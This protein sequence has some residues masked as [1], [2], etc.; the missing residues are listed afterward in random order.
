MEKS[1]LFS[2]RVC[3]CVIFCV[4]AMFCFAWIRQE[5]CAGAK[6]SQYV[7]LS[8]NAC[9]EPFQRAGPDA[10]VAL[11]LGCKTHVGLGHTHVAFSKQQFVIQHIQQAIVYVKIMPRTTQVTFDSFLNPPKPAKTTN[12]LLHG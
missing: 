10:F 1:S 5:R 12:P 3:E 7:D 11:G 4:V 2:S 8:N 6:N 9:L